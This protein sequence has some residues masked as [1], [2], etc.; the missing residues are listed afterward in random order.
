MDKCT[1][2][3]N[4]QINAIE[5]IINLATK[6]SIELDNEIEE[7]IN[8][9]KSIIDKIDLLSNEL[10]LNIGKS[11][12]NDEDINNLFEEMECLIDSVKNMV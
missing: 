9:S 2:L 7:R 8:I 12:S 1:K 3:F 4:D 10:A 11:K 6:D 5:T